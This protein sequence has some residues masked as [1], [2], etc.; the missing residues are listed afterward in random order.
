[1]P[2]AH[3]FDSLTSV[4]ALFVRDGICVDPPLCHGTSKGKYGSRTIDVVCV[5][6]SRKNRRSG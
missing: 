2:F 4:M 6:E 1:M 3:V 5:G